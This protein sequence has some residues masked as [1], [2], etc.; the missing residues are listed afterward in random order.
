[1]YAGGYVDAV[2]FEPCGLS[3]MISMRYGTLPVVRETGGLA[4]SGKT[5]QPVYGRRNRLLV[6]PIKTQM[7]WPEILFWRRR[8]L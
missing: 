7:K 3:Q 1:M 4:N 6:L 5:V 8:C 2:E